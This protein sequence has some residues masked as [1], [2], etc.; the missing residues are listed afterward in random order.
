[1]L[2]IKII[3]I[4]FF[5]SCS[6]KREALGPDNEIRIICSKSEERDIKKLL[7]ILFNDTI[8]TPE[9]EPYY[10]LKFSSPETYLELK[11]QAYIIVASL[12]QKNDNK[13]SRL[14]QKLLPENQYFI[15]YDQDPIY[16]SK[17]V[18]ARNQIFM[19][20]NGLSFDHVK[21]SIS[22]KK[23]QLKGLFL[24]QY[25]VRQK[26]FIID[27]EN[28]NKVEN[29]ILGKND[30]LISIPWGWEVIKNSTDSGFV[31]LGKE[32]PFQW[33]SVSWS[34]GS[35]IGDELIA[36]RYIW[37]MPNRYYKNIRFND[38]KFKLKKT[39]FLG[40]SAWYSDGI[41]ESIN[42]NESKGGP[43]RSYL[44]YN[45]RKNLTY[46]INML[47]YHPGNNKSLYMRQMDMIAKTFQFIER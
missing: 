18:H 20:V 15:N 28:Y 24:D 12:N 22:E 1:M 16:L 35:H 25:E 27:N 45:E 40:Y 44:F 33:I 32:M 11:N 19:V 30:W 3:L 37:D 39:N 36:G 17:N 5:L 41:W 43:F 6:S 10:F 31:W 4:I 29:S 2:F 46:H 38:Y 9:P 42:K 8:Y 7:S 26:K 47:I 23:D 34:G 13:A 21:R 14:I